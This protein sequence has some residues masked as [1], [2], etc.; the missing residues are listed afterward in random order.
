MNPG[1][2]GTAA[3]LPTGMSCAFGAVPA[4]AMATTT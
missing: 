1:R 4:P 3:R 2:Q